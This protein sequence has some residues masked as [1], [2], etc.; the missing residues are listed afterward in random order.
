MN[1][2]SVLYTILNRPSDHQLFDWLDEHGFSALA[3]ELRST[4]SGD[5]EHKWED[6]SYHG[7]PRYECDYCG[8][9]RGKAPANC[10][11]ALPHVVQAIVRREMRE[12]DEYLD[13]LRASARQEYLQGKFG[14]LRHL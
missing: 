2:R 1:Y 13:L 5:H 8:V 12:F 6:V 7:I 14:A 3:A 9:V 10:D 11:K 4:C